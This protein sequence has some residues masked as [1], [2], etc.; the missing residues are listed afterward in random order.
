MWYSYMKWAPTYM[1][2][3]LDQV[4][5]L[6]KWNM[7]Y[8]ST[9]IVTK[10]QPRVSTFTICVSHICDT[11][12]IGHPCLNV[13]CWCKHCNARYCNTC[14][15]R[16]RIDCGQQR[17]M[18]KLY[19]QV[20][21]VK[22]HCTTVTIKKQCPKQEKKIKVTHQQCDQNEYSSQHGERLTYQIW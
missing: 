15:C 8:R 6:F 20:Q 18:W 11:A 17:L 13:K 16:D 1:C 19:L 9:C 21:N 5:F 14:S 10:P 2:V 4:S 7:C 22:V 3:W 12:Q